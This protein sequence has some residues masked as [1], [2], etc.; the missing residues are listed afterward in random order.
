MRAS[1]ACR[2]RIK[3]REALR[4]RAY[5]DSAGVWTIGYGTTRYPNGAPVRKG[6]E[7]T[8]EEAE[9]WFESDMIKFE[10]GVEA[11]LTGVTLN[12]AL[13]DPLVS[14]AYNIGLRAF[15]KSTLARCLR[16]GDFIAAQ[17]E[18]DKWVNAGGE[19]VQGLVNRRNEEQLEFNNGIRALL[20]KEP[21]L[22]SLF[23][24]FVDETNLG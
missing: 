22:L 11:S 21:E 9:L 13:F 4:L 23:N 2:Q 6:D 7:C 8:L 17:A 3:D 19:K 12:Q 24:Q 15:D 20:V 5:Q 18:F 10:E 1:D 16:E 14:M